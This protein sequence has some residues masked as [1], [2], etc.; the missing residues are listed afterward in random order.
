MINLLGLIEMYNTYNVNNI[1]HDVADCLLKNYR[2]LDSMTSAQIADMCNVSPSTL[3]RF[4]R[5]MAYPMTVSKL[6]E[7][8]SQTKDNYTYEGNYIP[9]GGNRIKESYANYYIRSMQDGITYLHNNID[10]EQI[11][12]FVKDI[13][14]CKKVVFLGCPIPQEAWRFQVDLTLRG[15][16]SCAFLDPNHQFEELEQLKEGTIV[17]YTQYCKFGIISYKKSILERKDKIYKL[18]L[19]VNN[20]EHPLSPIADYIFSYAGNG[21]EQ[22][23]ILLNMYINIIAL[24]FCKN[25]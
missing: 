9:S 12:K 22:D 10:E 1:Y 6:P 7:I 20:V 8:A 3:N 24:T 19:L 15:I 13:Q 21:T 17:V 25:E 18:A 4:F 14:S 16:E 5:K 2:H 11:L 23:M